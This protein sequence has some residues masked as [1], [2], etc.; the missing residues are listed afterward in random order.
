MNS[1]IDRLPADV[2]ISHDPGDREEEDKSFEVLSA[3]ICTEIIPPDTCHDC[4]HTTSVEDQEESFSTRKLSIKVIAQPEERQSSPIISERVTLQRTS[5]WQGDIDRRTKIFESCKVKSPIDIAESPTMTTKNHF[6]SINDAL[7]EMKKDAGKKFDSITR[8]QT[9]PDPFQFPHRP[10]EQITLLNSEVELE[11]QSAKRK[12]TLKR[13]LNSEGDNSTLELNN[14]PREAKLRQTSLPEFH[15]LSFEGENVSGVPT[16]EL[17]QA[18]QLLCEALFIRAKYMALSMQN[19]CPT[20]A[21]CIQEVSKDYNLS[22]LLD[23]KEDSNCI[24]DRVMCAFQESEHLK[25]DGSKWMPFHGEIPGD[26]GYTF[27]M[28]DGVFQVTGC[29]RSIDGEPNKKQKPVIHPFPCI[30]E[31]LDDQNVLLAL[32]THGPVKSFSYRRLQF[33]ESKFKLHILLNEMKELAAQKDIPHRDFYNVRKVDTHVHAASC[34][35]Q[36]HLLRFIKKKAKKFGDEVVFKKTDQAQ[37]LNDVFKVLD[38][39]PYDLSVD[40][41]DVHADRNTFHRFDKFNSKYNPV[42]QSHLREV[43]LKTDNFIKGKY[44]AELIKEVGSDLEESKYQMA[45]LRISIYGRSKDEWDKLAKWAVKF[46]DCMTSTVTVNPQ[47]HPELHK[48]LA[49]VIGFDSVD[50]ESKPEDI[51]FNKFCPK[52]AS[53]VAQSNPPY[54]YYLYY[55]YS[56][57]VVLNHLRRERGFNIFNLRPHCGEAG[58]VHHLVTA[59]ML[60]ENIS[61]GL[62]LRKIPALQYLYY[63]AQIG[64]AMSPLSNNS[65]FLNY[66]RNP[67]PEYHARGLLVSISTDDPLQFHFTKEPLMEEYSI[68]AQVW[69]FSQTDMCELARN[70]VLMSGFEQKVKQHWL[71]E[72]LQEQGH[73]GNDIA[74]TNVPDIRVSFRH[75]TLL[76]ELRILESGAKDAQSP[77]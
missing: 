39:S 24:N 71:G 36:K 69:K 16:D 74:K 37:T 30:E 54:A 40:S 7:E 10:I 77:K 50:D 58:P 47:S 22:S 73:F 12:Q 55:I 62:L 43:F 21:K 41:L 64:I 9:V 67:L 17:R 51:M 20:T 42:G 27:E 34:M 19:F 38:L 52:P 68:V 3:N 35:N 14:E 65:L 63:L 25:A 44:F 23:K 70:S 29:R 59:F 13:P 72:H 1:Q 15:K 5:S 48:F 45:E 6:S 31:F 4:K 2:P 32:S 11:R 28:V 76:E 60:A 57:M 46:H 66:H 53:W 26:S 18:S 61:H 75:E 8:H 33:L 49:Q 56:N